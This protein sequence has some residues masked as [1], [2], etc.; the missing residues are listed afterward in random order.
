MRRVEGTRAAPAEAWWA[1][2]VV[3]FAFVVAWGIVSGFRERVR[4]KEA[5]AERSRKTEAAV[6]ERAKMMEASVDAR[7]KLMIEL[8]SEAQKGATESQAATDL[9]ARASEL[10][11]SLSRAI[12]R[13]LDQKGPS[14]LKGTVS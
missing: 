12:R 2:G 10:A 7:I 3:G 4:Q 5:E 14:T 1:L 11:E 13:G 6:A 8:L 9:V